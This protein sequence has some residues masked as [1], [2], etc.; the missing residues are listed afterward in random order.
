MRAIRINI[1]A[2]IIALALIGCGDSFN[3][4]PIV[5]FNERAWGG[6]REVERF[7]FVRDLINKGKLTGISK[8]EVLRM[9]G[10]PSYEDPNGRYVTYIVK[11][12]AGKLYI[13]DIRFERGRADPL[14]S[15]VL[16]RSD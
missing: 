1:Y 7:I 15:E 12:E 8:G 11:I 16:V 5:S 4:W 3:K 10:K 9:L 6:A 2:S 14:V 13:L